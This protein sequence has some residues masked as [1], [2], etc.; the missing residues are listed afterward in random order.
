MEAQNKASN[1]RASTKP[2]KSKEWEVEKILA[3]KKK[4]KS[5]YVR[6]SWVGHDED[7]EWYPISDFKTS[8]HLLMDFYRENSSTTSP[9]AQLPEW[10]D[11]YEAG[12]EDYEH[13]DSNKPMDPRSR[14]RYF[15]ELLEGLREYDESIVSVKKII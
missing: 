4:W 13:L 10:K 5:L 7:P 8:P 9:P 2:D 6:A 15:K 1:S 12:R 3:V 11:A 14:A